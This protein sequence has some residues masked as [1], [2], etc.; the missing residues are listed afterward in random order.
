MF[1]RVLYADSQIVMAV[2]WL[3]AGRLIVQCGDG[4]RVIAAPWQKS[5]LMGAMRELE[6][7]GVTMSH[8]DPTC[9][10]VMQKFA[11]ML[12]DEPSESLN[13]RTARHVGPAGIAA[14]LVDELRQRAQQSDDR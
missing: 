14:G 4:R 6:A 11:R 12:V 9:R 2:D 1:A 5:L 7:Q 10:L 13:W 3:G 8:T